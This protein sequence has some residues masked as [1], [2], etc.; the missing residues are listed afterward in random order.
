MSG[1][2]LSVL[3]AAHISSQLPRS[4]GRVGVARDVALTLAH[5]LDALSAEMRQR[6]VNVREVDTL[7][8][9]IATD[10]VTKYRDNGHKYPSQVAV[11]TIIRDA[12]LRL[13]N[14][15]LPLDLRSREKDP[16]TALQETR[17]EL[18]ALSR[19]LEEL[20]GQITDLAGVCTKLKRKVNQIEQEVI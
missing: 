15:A 20:V 7:A 3:I 8:E 10:W 1:R 9:M 17:T 19:Q 12:S 11:L 2:R 14:E 4:P 18:R 16:S 5:L 6:G 13:L